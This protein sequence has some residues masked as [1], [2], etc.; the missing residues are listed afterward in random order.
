LAGI[1]AF[2]LDRDVHAMQTKAGIERAVAGFWRK[3]C[4][5]SRY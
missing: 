1:V 5:S 2:L 4:H 3:Q